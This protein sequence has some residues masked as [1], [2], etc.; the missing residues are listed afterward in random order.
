MELTFVS[1]PTRHCCPHNMA[2]PWRC[3]A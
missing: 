2:S 3:E 1:P